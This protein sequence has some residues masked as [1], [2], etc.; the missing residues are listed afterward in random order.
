MSL[1]CEYCGDVVDDSF[2]KKER[3][4]CNN[5]IDSLLL[6]EKSIEQIQIEMKYEFDIKAG[7]IDLCSDIE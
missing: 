4:L 5:C 2:S 7:N 6:Y 3:V 1:I